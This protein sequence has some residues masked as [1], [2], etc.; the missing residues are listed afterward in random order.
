MIMGWQAI[1]YVT[2]GLS[3]VAF[4]ATALLFA[5]RY[6]LQTR[7]KI[8]TS[9]PEQERVEAIA[10]EAEFFRVQT[11]GLT[12]EQK[13]QI[14]LAQIHARERRTVLFG[15]LVFCV[16][17]L[18][19]LIA[20]VAIEQPK[21]SQPDNHV[22]TATWKRNYALIGPLGWPKLSS[23]P[24]DSSVPTMSRPDLIKRLEVLVLDGQPLLEDKRNTLMQMI[25]NA[26]VL[27]DKNPTLIRISSELDT[28]YRTFRA[29]LRDIAAKHYVNVDEVEKQKPIDPD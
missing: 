21:P 13:V 14:I 24:S 6:R 17:F 25:K 29:A 11:D 22:E 26:P 27:D 9:A 3:L 10:T 12:K 28:A 23:S 1:Q 15:A 20:I 7:A 18:L 4:L 5:Y 16:A 2:G 8:I 19:A